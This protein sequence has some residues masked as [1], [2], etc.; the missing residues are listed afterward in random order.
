MIFLAQ[1]PTPPPINITPKQQDI[2]NKIYNQD[3]EKAT[4]TKRIFGSCTY[5]WSGWKMSADRVRSTIRV[6]N[7][8]E[9]RIAV[10]CEAL[11]TNEY[12]NDKWTG[13]ISPVSNAAEKGEDLMVATLCSNV[14][15]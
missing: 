9:Q 5:D 12:V 14:V 10:S 11:K 15:K 6:C 1:I 3:F 7:G 13:W 8:K 4:E 2:L